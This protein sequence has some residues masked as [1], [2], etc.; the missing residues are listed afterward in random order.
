[1][2]T[3]SQP[4]MGSGELLP[5][6]NRAETQAATPAEVI[7]IPPGAYLRAMW[8][9]AWT[10][11]LRPFTDTTIDLSTGKIIDERKRD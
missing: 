4:N 5:D 2:A 8:N 10:A 3:T 6:G 9:L 1:M 11:F 7:Y